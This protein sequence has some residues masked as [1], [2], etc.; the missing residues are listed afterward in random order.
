VARQRKALMGGLQSSVSEFSGQVEGSTPKD[1]MDILLLTQYFDTL[2]AIGA[3]SLFLEHDPGTVTTMQ[4]S[5]GSSFSKGLAGGK[6]R[7]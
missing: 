6:G 1:V 7:R 2:S 5:V 4:A 3:N